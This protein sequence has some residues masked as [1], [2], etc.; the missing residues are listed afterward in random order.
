MRISVFGLGYVG[1]VSAACLAD[2]GHTVIGVDISSLKVEM[3]NNGQSPIIEDKLAELIDENV[4]A[5][6]LRATT[7]VDEAI[8][9]TDISLICVGTPSSDNGSLDL[10][11]IKRVSEQIGRALARPRSRRHIVILR[12]TVL[13]GTTETVVIPILEKTTGGQA[14]QKFGIVYNPEF[15]REGSSIHD[16]H[17]PPYTLLGSPDRQAA[18][19]AARLYQDIDAPV[20]FTTIKAAEM[21]KY[22]NNAFH[23]AKVVFA[24]EI[25]N[26]C[27]V[28]GIDSHEVMDIFCMDHKLNLSSYYLKPGFSFGGSCLPKDL[29]A[30]L[31]HSRHLDLKLPLLESILPSNQLQIQVA[32]N[33]IKG[34]GSK[35]VG[36]LGFSFKAGTDDLRESPA[37]L[38]VEN[39]IGKG[40]QV[41]VYDHNV[42]LARLQGANKAYIEKEIP[43]IASL[44]VDSVDALLAKSEVIVIG[45]KTP[46]FM[47]VPD[48]V[49]SHQTIIDLVRI[50]DRVSENGYQGIAW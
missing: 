20:R 34:T 25:G 19:E 6:R 27:K 45:N 30:L 41:Q 43:H 44:M 31:Y 38:L 49:G 14:G 2:L 4:S 17:N 23:A 11:Y 16:F 9:H 29:R 33:M 5:G 47:Q 18:A 39:L 12:S 22:A 24:N 36:V 1:C 3:I 35:K 37:V 10:T 40:Y 42:S 8:D 26:L 48:M 15:L 7:S 46:E 50:Q 21:I 32:L 13:P 28:Q